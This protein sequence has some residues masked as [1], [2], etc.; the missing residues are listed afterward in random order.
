MDGCFVA[1]A[2]CPAVPSIRPRAIRRDR[3]RGRPAYEVLAPTGGRAEPFPVRVTPPSP[4]I[5]VRSCGACP[6]ALTARLATF[7]LRRPIPPRH[8]LA[9]SAGFCQAH[10]AKTE[11]RLQAPQRLQRAFHAPASGGNLMLTSIAASAASTG[12]PPRPAAGATCRRSSSR[13]RPAPILANCV[14]PGLAKSDLA[15]WINHG[16]CY[17]DTPRLLRRALHLMTSSCQPGAPAI[18]LRASRAFTA[19][20]CAPVHRLRCRTGNPC[21]LAALAV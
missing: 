14:M 5:A 18:R 3:H 19:T 2:V 21:R 15:T 17:S 20:S 6:A 7:F 10:R 1:T 16:T 8:V 13:T 4:A 9:S 12:A 11:C